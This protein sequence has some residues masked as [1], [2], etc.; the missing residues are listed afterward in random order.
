MGGLSKK[1]YQ[2]NEVKKMRP[3]PYVTVDAGA[4]LFKYDRLL[5][6]RAEQDKIT[7]IGI[8]KA[9]NHMEYDAVAVSGRDLAG[10]LGFLKEAAKL[11]NFTWLS[12]NLIDKTTREPIFPAAIVKEAGLL[13]IGIIGITGQDNTGSFDPEDNAEILPWQQVLPEQV[14][15]L[16][17]TTDMIILLASL[18][19]QELTAISNQLPAINVA[20]FSKASPKSMNPVKVNQTYITQTSKQ[21]KYA[22]WLQISWNPEQ[23][24]HDPQELITQQNNLTRTE[25]MRADA[26]NRYKQ[27]REKG[28]PE[29]LY[30]N[31]ANKLWAYRDLVSKRDQYTREVE[32]LG[33]RVATLKQQATVGS[34]LK[35]TPIRLAR[36]MPDVQEVVAIVEEIKKNVNEAGRRP[37][38]DAR[39]PAQ[40]VG[41]PTPARSLPSLDEAME[42]PFLTAESFPYGG[43]RSCV[44]CHPQQAD[45]WLRSRHAKAYQTLVANGQQFNLDCIPCHVTAVFDGSEPY[46]QTLP[47]DL[48]QV[49][50]EACHGP[51]NQ[52]AINQGKD[53]LPPMPAEKTCRR[54]HTAD[55]DDNFNFEIDR[56]KLGCPQGK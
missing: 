30:K 53:P 54:C 51:A 8:I 36:D 28:N 43:W 42:L 55:R 25:Q 56:Q 32:E 13:K 37:R 15:A 11:S 33:Q 29:E 18:D 35:H 46:A 50:C 26:V 48:Q 41:Q 39:E 6:G 24:W 38:S 40:I 47:G 45:V 20:I 9:Y 1:A 52:H 34:S 21:G 5:K 10:G 7:A 22:G 14:E 12:A 44:Q 4:L 31:D 27:Y 49:S 2:Y 23:G 16:A 17:K 19:M 3:M